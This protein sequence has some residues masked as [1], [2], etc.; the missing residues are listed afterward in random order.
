MN[1]NYIKILYYKIGI[2]YYKNGD[3]FECDFKD[4]KIG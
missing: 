2:L 4:E 1:Y 3:K